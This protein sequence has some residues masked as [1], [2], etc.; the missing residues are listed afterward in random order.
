MMIEYFSAHGKAVLTKGRI[1]AIMQRMVLN[2]GIAVLQ[3]IED[4]T[5]QEPQ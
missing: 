5:G 4:T 2:A 3:T 1:S